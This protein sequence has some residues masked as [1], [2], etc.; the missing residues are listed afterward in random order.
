MNVLGHKLWKISQNFR[1]RHARCQILQNIVDR[2]AEPANARLAASLTWLDRN[3]F[4]V[5][6]DENARARRAR[7]NGRFA[8]LD[9]S[10][11][12]SRGLRHH[13]RFHSPAPR[14]R[15]TILRTKQI[16]NTGFSDAAIEYILSAT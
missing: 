2:D 13:N 7:V 6:R 9:S 12:P 4:T 11:G 8:S 16:V 5:C 1:F 15:L 10:D 3:D 14:I